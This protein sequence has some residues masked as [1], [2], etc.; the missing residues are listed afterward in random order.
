MIKE[1]EIL[2]ILS[3]G[4]LY[5][6][7]S[8]KN[9]PGIFLESI[10]TTSIVLLLVSASIAMSW[11]M[12]YENIPQSITDLF[13]SVSDN[14]VVIFIL[15]NLIL[16]FVGIFMDI[17]PAILIFTPIFLPVAASIG[18]DPLQFGMILM[19]NLGLGLCT[20]PVGACLF[21]GCAVGNVPIERAVRT[22]WPFYAAIFIALMLTTF[23]PAISLTL[24]NL[25]GN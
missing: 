20:P 8:L 22:I 1:T 18:V 25:L 9:L 24:P 15:I 3:K 21:V 19:M 7:I 10:N 6:E 17:T 5:K 23:V 16:L 4:F 14:R 11:V 13:L 12:A 2:D